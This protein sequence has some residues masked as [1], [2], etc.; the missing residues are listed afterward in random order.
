MTAKI[1]NVFEEEDDDVRLENYLDEE[2]DKINKTENENN[3][4]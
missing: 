4:F 2:I 1:I 3:V